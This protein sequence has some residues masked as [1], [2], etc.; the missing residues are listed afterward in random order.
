MCGIYGSSNRS[1]F[2]VLHDANKERGNFATGI[3]GITSSNMYQKKTPQQLPTTVVETVFNDK[4][5]KYLL[6]HNQAPTSSQRKWCAETSHPFCHMPWLVAHNGVLTNFEQLNKQ[7]TPWNVNPV[8]SSVISAML[9]KESDNTTV[10][11]VDTE[12]PII[13]SVVSRLQGTFA[14]WITN[15]YTRNIY[16]CRQGSTLYY[17]SR[18]D[19]SSISS[20]DWQEVLEGD[21]IKISK[22]PKVVGKFVNQSPFF[23]L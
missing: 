22:R 7:Y 14:L 21:I 2:A 17:N 20:K 8:D 6:G 12:V 11:D 9:Q 16:I 13:E 5:I 10:W 18:G 19:F 1:L 23:V 4:K 3:V 15:E